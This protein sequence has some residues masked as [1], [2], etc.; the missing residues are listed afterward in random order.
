MFNPWTLVD[1]P[2]V[3]QM[4]TDAQNI[5]NKYEKRFVVEG[6]GAGRKGILVGGQLRPVRTEREAA[7]AIYVQTNSGYGATVPTML[8]DELPKGANF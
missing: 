5:I 4:S 1:K 7:A 8:F 2:N 6:Q 3:V